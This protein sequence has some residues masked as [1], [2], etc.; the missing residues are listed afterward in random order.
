MYNTQLKGRA[1]T[2]RQ[3]TF[4]N[5]GSSLKVVG[6]YKMERD[7]TVLIKEVP[8]GLEVMDFSGN[9]VEI[10]GYTHYLMAPIGCNQLQSKKFL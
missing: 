5:S 9:K 1:N 3:Q 2:W 6:L 4:N 7:G 10:P 8:Q